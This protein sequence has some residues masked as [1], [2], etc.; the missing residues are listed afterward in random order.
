MID[1]AYKIGAYRAE[2]DLLEKI[3]RVGLKSLAA[4]GLVGGLTGA[5]GSQLGERDDGSLFLDPAKTDPGAIGSGVLTGLGAMGGMALG[6]ALRRGL[7]PQ[8]IGM[9]VGGFA[10]PTLVEAGYR[11]LSGGY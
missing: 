7:L 6:G 4:A 9:G 2:E 5:F 1:I 3:S 8:G 10:A 11:N